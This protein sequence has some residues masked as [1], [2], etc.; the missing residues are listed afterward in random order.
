[1]KRISKEIPL[2]SLSSFMINK[3]KPILCIFT[4]IRA[5]GNGAVANASKY[6]LGMPCL[7]I[8]LESIGP[9]KQMQGE[10]LY[11][12]IQGTM[13]DGKSL[14]AMKLAEYVNKSILG[15]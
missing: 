8:P 10:D 5:S 2:E 12:S 7:V 11:K 13:K 1:M 14:S 3:Y 15:D 9:T 6:M 4:H